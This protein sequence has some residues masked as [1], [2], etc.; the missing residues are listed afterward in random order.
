MYYLGVD[1]CTLF[2]L[3]IVADSPERS[4]DLQRK[5]RPD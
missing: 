2:A 1:R 4:E 3:G 5:A